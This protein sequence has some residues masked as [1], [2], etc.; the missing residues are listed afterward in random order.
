MKRYKY[1]V[2]I[3]NATNLVIE[4]SVLSYLGTIKF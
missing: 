3:S 1:I 4:I 2:K